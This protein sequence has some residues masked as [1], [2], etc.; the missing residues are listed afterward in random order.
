MSHSPYKTLWDWVSLLPLCSY[1][2]THVEDNSYFLATAFAWILSW[3]KIYIEWYILKLPIWNTSHWW[4]KMHDVQPKLQSD[5]PAGPSLVYNNRS[6]SSYSFDSHVPQFLLF[7]LILFLLIPGWTAFHWS[8]SE[9][10]TSFKVKAKADNQLP[11]PGPP[12]RF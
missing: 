12:L 5:H 3:L 6:V 11:V 10:Q 2:I 1:I 9:S 8:C 4:E 7:S